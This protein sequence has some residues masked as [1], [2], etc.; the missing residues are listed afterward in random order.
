MA[1]LN[2]AVNSCDDTPSAVKAIHRLDLRP[3]V[4]VG[5]RP[6]RRHDGLE[7]LNE[8]RTVAEMRGSDCGES[9]AKLNA[10]L[11]PRGHSEQMNV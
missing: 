11:G 9:F 10:R 4:G 8:S 3:G 5:C 1:P 6:D 2:S 7:D